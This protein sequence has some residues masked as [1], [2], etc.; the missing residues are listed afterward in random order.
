[1]NIMKVLKVLKGFLKNQSTYWISNI[2]KVPKNIYKHP[3]VLL[4][5]YAE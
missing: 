1:M 3:S 5:L 4:D 2:Y